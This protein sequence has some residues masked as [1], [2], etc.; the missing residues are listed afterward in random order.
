MVTLA[1]DVLS[2]ELPS[3]EFGDMEDISKTRIFRTTRGGKREIYKDPIWPNSKILRVTFTGITEADKDYFLTLIETA[4]GKVVTFTDHESVAHDG[5]I[6]EHDSS[7]DIIGCG[8]TLS[9]TFEI[10]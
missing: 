6:I 7:Q 1:Y 4:I 3:P 2:L 5:F 10:E 9:F 8:F